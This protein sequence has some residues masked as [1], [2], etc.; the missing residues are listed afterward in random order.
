MR[1]RAQAS[2]GTRPAPTAR[3]TRQSTPG[4]SDSPGTPG[5]TRQRR[6]P[7]SAP[8]RVVAR[9]EGCCTR[10]DHDARR[11]RRR[12]PGRPRRPPGRRSSAPCSTHA[13][14]AVSSVALVEDVWEGLPP[15]DAAGAVQALVSRARRLGFAG[16]GRA[17]RLP[18]AHRRAADRRRRRRG[19]PHARPGRRCGRATPARARDLGREARDAGPDGARPRRPGDHP[20]ARRRRRRPGRGGARPRPSVDGVADDLRR[21]ALR[22][23][24]DEPLVALLVR[25]LAAQ[26]R[27]A[28]ALEVVEHV[29]TELADR[30][31]TDPSPVVAQAHLALLRGE[32]GGAPLPA[33]VA[34]LPA[35]LAPRGDPAGRPRRRRRR[36]R[37]GA[38]HVGA[39]HGRG[40]RRGRQDAPGRRGRAPR[41]RRG[42][43][44][45]RRRAGRS[46]R[47][48]PRCC[49]RCSPRS[50]GRTRPR[51]GPTCPPSAACSP[52]RTGCGSPRRTSTGCWCSTTAS[53]CSTRRRSS[54]ATCSPSPRPTWRCWRRAAR[55]SGSSASP[56]TGCGRS[57]TTTPSS[58]SSRARAPDGRPS[59]GSPSGRSSCAT[60]W[61]TC[62]S[63]SSWPP[64]GCGR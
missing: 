5:T 16:R 8:D 51:P 45:A 3:S 27:D 58:C 29:R 37:G 19:A 39:G 13:G 40:H 7:A 41:G 60:G 21:L 22:T 36:G 35:G 26:G 14:A 59:A 25:V 57:P 1:G 17:G 49:P 15:D 24:P 18:A 30:Y 61:T 53:T 12:R 11:A 48:P 2:T 50:A 63:R 32:L 20:P 34:A 23:P 28:E 52:P 46:A 44:R 9:R 55:R 6:I 33:V 64:P 43:A 4:P 42:S 56:C 10:A 47:R 31:G 38:P 62:R 54:S